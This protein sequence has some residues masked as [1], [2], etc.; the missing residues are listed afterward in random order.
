MITPMPPS[1]I[2]IILGPS[3]RWYLNGDKATRASAIV[4]PMPGE[5][6]G[7]PVLL[8]SEIT[9]EHVLKY[10]LASTGCKLIN[11]VPIEEIRA[12]KHTKDSFK[13]TVDK[14]KHTLIK[15]I[16]QNGIPNEWA[17]EIKTI[18]YDFRKKT[19]SIDTEDLVIFELLMN[20]MNAEERINPTA[21][22]L[23]LNL[24]RNRA[25]VPSHVD[26]SFQLF[27][28]QHLAGTELSTEYMRKKD[29]YVSIL[30]EL[31]EFI[32][33]F[34]YDKNTLSTLWTVIYGHANWYNTVERIKLY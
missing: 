13:E 18:T 8:P 28:A 9:Q 6:L 19:F 22:P 15:D 31:F 10:Q 29:K 7:L 32:D 3:P 26:G 33:K 16:I 23:V 25:I 30:N 4:V 12:D 2:E 1:P 5:S 34:E 11:G 21:S 20:H 17:N 14:I 27:T 24:S